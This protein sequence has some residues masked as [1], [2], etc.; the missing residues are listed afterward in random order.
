MALKRQTETLATFS[1]ASMTDLAFLL[2]IFFMVTSTYVFPTALEVNLP[3]GVSQSPMKPTTRVYV[4]ADGS[5]WGQYDD[6]DAQ[7]FA[8][9]NSLIEFLQTIKAQDPESGIAVYADVTVEYGE[10]VRVLNLG[11]ANDLKMVLATT[12]RAPK[13]AADNQQTAQHNDQ[14]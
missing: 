8:D 11:A 6:A 12:P 5:I 9:D 10:V 14:Q 4:Q 13:T 1:M 2:L 3:Q 7:Q